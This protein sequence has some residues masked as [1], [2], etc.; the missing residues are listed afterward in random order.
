MNGLFSSIYQSILTFWYSPDT[1]PKNLDF[2]IDVLSDNSGYVFITSISSKTSIWKYLFSSPS[3]TLCYSLSSY[4]KKPHGQLMINDNQFFFLVIDSTAMN[5]VYAKVTYGQNSADWMKTM[6]CFL[7]SNDWDTFQ[8]SVSLLGK[9]GSTIYLFANLGPFDKDLKIAIQNLYLFAFNSNDGSLIG[10]RY[11]SS[12]S[13]SFVN[14][15]TAHGDL[16]IAVTL[17]YGYNIIIYNTQTS[18]FIIKYISSVELNGVLVEKLS[19][20]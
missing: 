19:E 17:C 4:S 3:N 7:G 9:D 1:Y 2:R 10:T 20:R 8:S 18:L 11:K 16:L 12:I 15:A 13:C 14:D 6:S 5:I